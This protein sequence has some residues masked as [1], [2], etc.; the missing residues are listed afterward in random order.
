MAE[1]CEL[2]YLGEKYTYFKAIKTVL[3]TVILIDIFLQG[4]Y[5][6]PFLNPETNS[7]LYNIFNAIGFI[8]V[9]E[10]EEK[11]EI[12]IDQSIQVFS[13]AIIYLLISLQILIYESN[14][15]KRYYL[16]YLLS[17]KNESKKSSIINSFTFNNR[18]V[19]LYEKSLALRQQSGEAMEDLK[20]II[21]ELNGKSKKWRN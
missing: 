6:T 7:F 17:H 10:I 1:N 11:G 3:R 5:Q 2:L 14:H 21:N 12:K 4:I 16:V 8:K 20:N 15:F 19:E 13:K 9:I 18:R